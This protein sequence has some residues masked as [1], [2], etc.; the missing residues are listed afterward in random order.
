[1]SCI[2]NESYKKSGRA[3]CVITALFLLLALALLIFGL[4]HKSEQPQVFGRYSFNYGLLLLG[5]FSTVVYLSW[6]FWRAGPRLERWTA[7]L[8]VLLISTLIVLLAVEWGLR[9]FNPF[10]V[11]FF[12][13]L[14][15][16]MQ[17]MVD[18]PQLG[19]KHPASVTYMLGADQVKINAHGL[20]DEEVPYTKPSDEKRI[21]VLGDSV[22]FGWGI[23][24]GESFSDRMEPLLREQTGE[25]WQVINAGVNGY[26]TEQEATFLRIEGMRYSPDYVLLIYVSNDVDPVFDPNE[27]TWRRYPTWPPSLPEAMSRLRQVSY[28]FQLTHLLVRMEKMDLARA[29]AENG[30]GV[31]SAQNIRSMTGHP[32][33][34]SSK[35]ALLDIAQQCKEAGIPF[36]VGLY[37][38]LD[39]GYDPAFVAELQEAGIDTIPLQPS[40]KGVP[41]NVAHVSRID[42]HPSALVH[43]KMAE[44]L[45]NVFR[46]RGWLNKTK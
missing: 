37:S 8:Y 22:T 2:T 38:S 3:F 17:G 26:N 40:W 39:S 33:W 9:I 5:L 43:E 6:V 34:P 23:S 21:L 7:N 1:M 46:I 36:L 27:T 42:S 16:H 29:A 10:G 35:A 14:P 20:R 11:D 28:L 24:Q 45:V 30:S 15:Y 18:D 12:H 44:Y 4:M 31:P 41:E 19:F 32:N 13:I 25:R